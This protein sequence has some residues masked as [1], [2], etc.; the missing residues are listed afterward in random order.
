[1]NIQAEHKTEEIDLD[2][3]N[4]CRVLG[5][6]LSH[7][8]LIDQINSELAYKVRRKHAALLFIDIDD[9]GSVNN[10]HGHEVGNHI[11]EV[12]FQRLEL[13]IRGA[14][15]LVKLPGDEFGVFIHIN[16][17]SEAEIV[18]NRLRKVCSEVI[19]NDADAYHTSISTGVAIYPEDGSTGEVIL[20]NA[21][22]AMCCAKE[23]GKNIYQFHSD[24]M[25]RNVMHRVMMETAIRNGIDKREFVLYYQPQIELSSGKIIGTEVLLRWH[26]KNMI[27]QPADFISLAEESGLID[28]LGEYVINQGCRQLR[29]WELEGIED[30]TLSINVSP[31]QFKVN[32]PYILRK[33]IDSSKI[34]PNNLC[35]EI[36]ESCLMGNIEQVQKILGEIAEMGVK[37]AID[38]F[39][40]GYSSLSYL[41]SLPINILK[42]PQ[43]F[44][45]KINKGND[46]AITSA[47]IALAKN[48]RLKTIGEGVETAEQQTALKEIGCDIVQGHLHAKAMKADEFYKLL[49]KN[50][51]TDK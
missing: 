38:D 33:H 35:I 47:I 19:V 42:I 45:Q 23:V 22:I 1:M 29:R 6:K 32:L 44:I 10:L 30:L 46:K 7:P 24:E 15:M 14:D 12:I 9:L 26:T 3:S 5:M 13:N 50:T 39:G 11:L 2:P 8:M 27:I 43:E 41:N 48:M 20:K 25:N 37:I 18:A 49:S 21:Q 28:P 16:A 4:S 40:T 34:N 51:G 36:T 17:P 31:K